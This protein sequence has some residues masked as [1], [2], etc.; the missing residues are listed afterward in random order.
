MQEFFPIAD[1]EEAIATTLKSR[2]CV[3][4]VDDSNVNVKSGRALVLTPAPDPKFG[5]RANIYSYA[6]AQQLFLF[7]ERHAGKINVPV[8]PQPFVSN[9]ENASLIRAEGWQY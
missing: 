2:N 5:W 1:I 9:N 8:Q 7:L 4:V 3:W 6:W